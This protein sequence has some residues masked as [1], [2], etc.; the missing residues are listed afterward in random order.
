MVPLLWMRG[1][2][3]R[4]RDGSLQMRGSGDSA[5]FF[6]NLSSPRPQIVVGFLESLASTSKDFVGFCFTGFDFEF[7]IAA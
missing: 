3:G 5:L 7:L 2:G 1:F 4:R 6:H